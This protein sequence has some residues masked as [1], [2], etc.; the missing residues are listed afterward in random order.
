MKIFGAAA[1]AISVSGCA[2]S[3]QQVKSMNWAEL[4][5]TLGG[6]ALGGYTGAQFGGG[7]ANT[8]FIAS[9]VFVGG[10]AGYIGA[11][12]LDPSDQAAYDRTVRQALNE[13]PDG[14]VVRWQNP[15]TGRSGIFRS[16]AS[17]TRSGGQVCRQYRSSVVFDDGVFNGGGTACQQADGRWMKLHDEFS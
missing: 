11:R 9:G 2:E 10:A 16:V 7:L 12:M 13:A 4:G 8:I 14:R 6:A 5:G 3:V 15:Q 1:V 17:Y